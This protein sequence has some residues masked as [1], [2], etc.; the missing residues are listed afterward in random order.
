MICVRGVCAPAEAGQQ[1][2]TRLQEL[3]AVHGLDDPDHPQH[4][5]CTVTNCLAVCREGPVM[6]VH[7]DGIRYKHLDEAA[8]ERI[9]QQ[10]FLQNQPVDDLIF[11]DQPSRSVLEKR[12]HVRYRPRP[13]RR[14]V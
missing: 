9:F 4:V 10:H 2:E 14:N 3:I 13:R 5:R 11:K 8:L 1:L 7:P 6:M 12:E